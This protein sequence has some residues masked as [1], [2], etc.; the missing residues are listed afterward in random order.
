M[1]C[2]SGCEHNPGE[3]TASPFLC[4]VDMTESFVVTC[5]DVL[6]VVG[7]VRARGMFGGHGI[8]LG[9][10]MFAL[11]ADDALYLKVDE[12]TRSVFD[13]A[14]SVPFVYHGKKGRPVTMSYREMPPEGFESPERA[15]HWAGLAI[16]AARRRKK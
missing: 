13:E 16:D 5:L 9:E 3:P 4:R 8:Y 10:V 6:S 14:E 12:E 1:R 2:W 15:E 7:S 11:I